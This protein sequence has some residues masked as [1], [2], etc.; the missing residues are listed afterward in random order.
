MTF[1]D[2]S[3]RNV[4]LKELYRLNWSTVFDTSY[5]DTVNRWPNWMSGYQ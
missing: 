5:Q 1:V 2:S 3:V 4:G